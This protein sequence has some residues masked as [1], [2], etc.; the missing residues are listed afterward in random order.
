MSHN[1]RFALIAICVA[2][3][4]AGASAQRLPAPT[5]ESVVA[6]LK[7]ADPELRRG[8]LRALGETGYPEAIGPISTLLRDPLDDIQREALN[9]LIGFFVAE[10]L[11]TRRYVGIVELRNT[12]LAEAAFD[13]GPYSVIF[14]PVPGEL[15][16]NLA[17]AMAD[18]SE[19]TRL[20]AVYALGVMAR[21]SVDGRTAQA[22]IR[23]LED[24]EADIRRA[25]A[26][27]AGRLRVQQAGN[28]LIASMNDR[29]ESVRIAAMRAVGEVREWRALQALTDFFT[30]YERGP[31]A[32]AALEGLAHIAHA[33]SQDLFRE[34]LGDGS[35]LIRRYAVEGLA[36]SG[37][38]AAATAAATALES[39]Q[40]E[41][42][43]LALA[44]ASVASRGSGAETLTAGLAEHERY[45]QAMDYF[46]ELGP[47]ALPGLRAALQQS[48]PLVRQRAAIVLGFIGGSDALAL[49][50]SAER[51]PDA[52][53][54]RAAERA[55]ARIRQR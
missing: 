1:G 38:R 18:Q 28:A 53:V 11:Q 49:L 4:V 22:L 2:L 13:L 41:G 50:E 19:R 44:F 15:T 3:G 24:P 21:P 6:Q 48:A 54:A 32:E 36:R 9:T 20:H 31:L 46:V 26:R 35:P 10:P 47:K 23:L 52:D 42:V 33:S 16:A 17:S 39:E 12:N 30:Y 5:F 51:D 43:R 27:V 14:Q 7:S 37:N 45:S 29:D 40:D 8:A 34:R 55:A 25:A